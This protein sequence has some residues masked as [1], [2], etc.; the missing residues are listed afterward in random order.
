MASHC[1][2]RAT[3]GLCEAPIV[4]FVVPRGSLVGSGDRKLEGARL[5]KDHRTATSELEETF[6]VQPA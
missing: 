6:R 3:T 4:C 1:Q 2:P 5:C